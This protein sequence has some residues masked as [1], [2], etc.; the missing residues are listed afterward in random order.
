MDKETIQKYVGHLIFL[1]LKNGLRYKIFLNQ[2][3]IINDSLSF[4]GK[5]GEPID[6]EI[7]E[8]S[9]ITISNEEVGEKE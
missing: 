3:C 5:F 9:F 4:I 8:I 2:E 7:S 1:T 6:L